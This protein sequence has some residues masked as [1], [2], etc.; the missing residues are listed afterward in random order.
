MTRLDRS[1]QGLIGAITQISFNV[2]SA[3]VYLGIALLVMLRLEYR[4]TKLVCAE[5]LAC[6]YRTGAVWAKSEGR[7]RDSTIRAGG[8]FP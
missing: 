7:L 2:L 3:A 4:L 8:L 5:S 6:P 1:V